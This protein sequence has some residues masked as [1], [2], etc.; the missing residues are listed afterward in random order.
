M[1]RYWLVDMGEVRYAVGSAGEL[2]LRSAPPVSRPPLSPVEMAGFTVLDG[3]T[4][5]L[6]DLAACI[7]LPPGV[8]P[9]QILLSG[10]PGEIAL[11]FRGSCRPLQP[12]AAEILPLP[13]FLQS[14]VSADS[15]LVDGAVIPLLDFDRLLEAISAPDWELPRPALVSSPSGGVDFSGEC[16]LFCAAGTLF[17]APAGLFEGTVLSSAAITPVAATP[18]MVAGVVLHEGRPL[19]VIDL[20]AA[21]HLPEESRGKGTILSAR[22]DGALW[23]FLVAEDRGTIPVAHDALLPLPPLARRPAIAHALEHGGGLVPC[24]DLALLLGGEEEA[25]GEGEEEPAEGEMRGERTDRVL[26]FALL[27]SHYALPREEVVDVQPLPGYWPLPGM[28]PLLLGLTRR[29]GTLWP[30]IDLTVYF[31]CRQAIT[32]QSQ[33]IALTKGDFNAVIVAG[34]VFGER[35]IPRELQRELPFALP[36]PLVYG[37]YLQE[38]AVLLVLNARS[39]ALHFSSELAQDVRGTF[40][41]LGDEAPK[42]AAP[43]AAG[44]FFTGMPTPVEAQDESVVTVPEA[45][46]QESEE[47]EVTEEGRDSGIRPLSPLEEETPPAALLPTPES[48]PPLLVPPLRPQE[49]PELPEL[50]ARIPLPKRPA[51]E[52]APPA[53]PPD[54]QGAKIPPPSALPGVDPV[55]RPETPVIAPPTPFRPGLSSVEKSADAELPTAQVQNAAPPV[56]EAE[57]P[58]PRDEPSA[59]P[60]L[61]PPVEVVLNEPVE[62]VA[63]AVCPLPSPLGEEEPPSRG[64][65]AGGRRFYLAAAAVVLFVAFALYWIIPVDG[66]RARPGVS[67]PS[68]RERLPSTAL[69]AVVPDKAPYVAAEAPAAAVP[70]VEVAATDNP[71][72][73]VP[74]IETPV[75][76][77]PG[78]GN[79]AEAR[80]VVAPLTEV[81]GVELAPPPFDPPLPGAMPAVE[82][83]EVRPG[84]N[85]WTISRRYMGDPWAFRQLAR[86][87]RIPEPDL[88]FPGQVIQ[89]P[90]EA[91]RRRAAP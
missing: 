90:A 86:E 66:E 47:G 14:P 59:L 61:P 21:L 6:L 62:N 32:A 43:S 41:G 23:G 28:S 17:A 22:L 9:S 91:K 81:P 48:D 69:P 31:G 3:R 56:Q 20:A 18:P 52:P 37:C 76:E 49:L 68:A 57:K 55:E 38:S 88:I 82:P 11:H 36:L 50:A 10:A 58:P 1:S 84:D 67:S 16:R 42:E 60:P 27:G 4:L 89:L 13:P 30:V 53:A 39:M 46:C 54:S 72:A 40:L 2:E 29:D 73:G 34:E 87:N 83:Y 33:G 85:L 24:L 78:A 45:E 79:S 25:E 70:M 26:E 63:G 51:A 5:T 7:G 71:A 64:Q 77:A 65:A 12:A 8:G 74:G 75:G 19:T 44:P 80:A 35:T 15:L